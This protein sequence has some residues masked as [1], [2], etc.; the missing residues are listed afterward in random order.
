MKQ[1]E[2]FWAVFNPKRIDNLQNNAHKDIGKK[3]KFM[4]ETIIDDGIYQGQYR[5]SPAVDW[6][7]V[8]LHEIE[9]TWAPQCDLDII[10]DADEIARLETALIK[11]A[12]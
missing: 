6:I 9:W 1:Y 11:E 7:L 4:A 2:K 12:K 5:C 10:T 3:I 8:Y